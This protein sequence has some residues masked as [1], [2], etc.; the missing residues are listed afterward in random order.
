MCATLMSW[1]APSFPFCLHCLAHVMWQYFIA[2]VMAAAFIYFMLFLF[3]R[4]FQQLKELPQ[5]SSCQFGH[6]CKAS[7]HSLPDTSAFWLGER[8]EKQNDMLF[9]VCAD[10][11]FCS[12]NWLCQIWLHFYVLVPHNGA[13]LLWLGTRSSKHT[14]WLNTNTPEN[15]IKLRTSCYSL[16]RS[17]FAFSFF[18]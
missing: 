9:F 5:F 13:R 6:T 2:A 12:S 15:G 7:A 11:H 10:S 16:K 18:K 1:N 8:S 17:A 4:Y 3:P 14:V